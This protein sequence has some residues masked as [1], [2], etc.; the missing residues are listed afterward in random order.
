MQRLRLIYLLAVIALFTFT[1]GAQTK[2]L[3]SEVK[4]RIDSI[5]HQDNPQP[6]TT[7]SVPPTVNA[8]AAPAIR[9][10]RVATGTVEGHEYV[11]LGLGIKW[12]T[13]NVGAA[14]PQDMGAYYAWGET[15]VSAVPFFQ[16]SKTWLEDCPDFSGD[17]EYDAA[18]ALW[19]G[20]WRLPTRWEVDELLTR[21]QWIFTRE[22]GVWGYRVIGPNHNSIFLPAAGNLLGLPD[23]NEVWT[24]GSYW[25]SSPDDGGNENSYYLM[26]NG[27]SWQQSLGN[28]MVGM[29]LRPVCD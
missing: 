5:K 27:D 20:A 28:R 1:A 22:E 10:N 18:R 21:C 7:Q 11:D 6:S 25:T 12:A 23:D 17:E 3:P 13:S 26:F 2:K 4:H 9:Y 15:T 8:Q 16:N 19:H 24:S 29:T 14:K